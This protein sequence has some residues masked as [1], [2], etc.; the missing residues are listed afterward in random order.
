MQDSLAAAVGEGLTADPMLKSLVLIVYGKLSC[1]GAI[2]LKRGFLENR[3]M[4]SLEVK[5]FGDLPDNWATV[6]EE[7]IRGK[8]VSYVFNSSSKYH[9]Q[10]NKCTSSSSL[11]NFKRKQFN[12]KPLG[13]VEL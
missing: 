12:I 13:R 8:K 9:W 5:V 7:C 3:S 1:S 10:H 6:I 4:N 11:S 2:S